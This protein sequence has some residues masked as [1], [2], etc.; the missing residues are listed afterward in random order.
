MLVLTRKMGEEIV[1]GDNIHVMVVAIKGDTVRI[2][3]AAPEE[4]IVDRQEVYERRMKEKPTFSATPP[5]VAADLPFAN[6]ALGQ[7]R[8]C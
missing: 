4:V 1:I 2:G 8:R 6:V 3:I 7:G 5:D